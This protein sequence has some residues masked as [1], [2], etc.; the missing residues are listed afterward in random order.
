ML[1][2]HDQA[3]V[4]LIWVVASGFGAAALVALAVIYRRAVRRHELEQAERTIAEH[5]QSE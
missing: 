4:A 1:G 2:G 3:Y 5:D